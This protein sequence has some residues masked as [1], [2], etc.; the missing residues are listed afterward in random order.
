MNQ[1]VSDHEVRDD[2]NSNAAMEIFLHPGE[3]YFGS[4]PTILTC[5]LRSRM[6]ITFWHQATRIG[7]MSHVVLAESPDGAGDMRHADRAIAE[8]SALAKKYQTMPSEYEVH[9]IGGSGMLPEMQSAVGQQNGAINLQRVK[10]FLATSGFKVT[11]TNV[12]DASSRKVKFDLETGKLHITDSAAQSSD[13]SAVLLQ[14]ASQSAK[15]DTGKDDSFTMEIFLHPGEIYFGQAPTIVSTLLGSC[16]AVT[17]WHPKELLG[18]MCHIVLPEATG[19][20]CDMKYGDCAIAEF[21]KQAIKYSTRTEDYIVQVHGGSDMFPDMKKSSGMKI[22]DRNLEKV[23]Q[24]LQLYKF[25][26][27]EVDT[28]GNTSRK[29]KLDLSSGSVEARKTGRI[30]EG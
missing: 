20:T 8:F 1:E 14:Q 18:G 10:S 21:S 7:G 3:L 5:S 17:L 15:K 29:I 16:V 25:K 24:L 27:S 2:S 13:Q 9:I 23:N 12:A 30:A 22:G 4:A 26:V 6:V 11:D 19:Q 28:G